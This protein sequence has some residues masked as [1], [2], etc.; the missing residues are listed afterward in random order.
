MK[1][2]STLR[3]QQD[4]DRVFEAGRWRRLHAVAIGVYHRDDDER[5]RLAFVAGQRIGTAVRR[6]RSRRRMREAVRTLSD[7]IMPGADIVLAARNAAADVAFDR[8]QE[9]IREV[10]EAEGLLGA[11]KARDRPR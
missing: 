8:L 10:L 6:N 1:N 3:R 9:Q 7:E 2:L 5:S 11:A 4:L